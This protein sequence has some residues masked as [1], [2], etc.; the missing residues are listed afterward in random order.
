VDLDAVIAALVRRVLAEL[1]WRLPITVATVSAN[2][3]V[4][5]TRVTAAPPGS[6]AGS[7]AI[8]HVTGEVAD[9]GF[10][11]PLHLMLTDATGR[12]RLGLARGSGP[13]VLMAV[14]EEDA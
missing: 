6:A 5:F 3:G 11:A 14:V 9:E 1:K 12:V 7:V 4:V 2:G 10:A 13:P 8:E